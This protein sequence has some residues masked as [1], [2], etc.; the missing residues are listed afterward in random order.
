[1]WVRNGLQIKGQAMTYIQA[2]FCNSMV[3]MDIYWLQ[4]CAAHLPPDLFIDMCIDT[5]GV[6]EWLSMTPMSALQAAEQDAMVEGLLTFLAILVS[7]RTNLG[8]DEVSQSRLEVATLLACGDKTHSQLLELIPEREPEW[9]GA[10]GVESEAGTTDA[11]GNSNKPCIMSTSTALAIPPSMQMF[12]S[13]GVPIDDGERG[14]EGNDGG[15]GEMRALEEGTAADAA[16]DSTALV[17]PGA[18][19]LAEDMSLALAAPRDRLHRLDH[20]DMDASPTIDY[21]INPVEWGARAL[22]APPAESAPAHCSDE[23]QLHSALSGRLDSFALEEP[24]PDSD[25]HIGD[26]PHFIGRVLHKLAALD[27]RCADAIQMVRHSLWPHQRERE[28]EQRARERREKEERSRR[29]RERQ[30]AVMREFARRQQQFLS[31][32]RQLEGEQGERM[33]CEGES[34]GEGEWETW[35]ARDYDCV[36]C[37]TRARASAHDPIGLVV[38]LQSSSVLGHRRRADGGAGAL[39]L[40]EPERSRLAAHRAATAAAHH[41]R[42]HDDLHQHFDQE[43]WVLSVNVGW[44]GGVVAQSCGHHVHLRCLRAYLRSLA[45]P[46]PPNLLVERGEFLCP[47]CRQLANSVLPL[48]P[49]P[50]PAPAPAAPRDHLR[51]AADVSEM[52]E[53]E[54]V[55]MAVTELS[56]AMG[57]AMTDM[58]NAASGKVKLQHGSSPAAIF[59]FMASL[60]RTNL[61]C[62]LVQ[63][64]NTL[65]VRAPPRYKPRDDCIVPL[66]S[67]ASVHARALLVAGSALGVAHTW[68][69]LVP[70]LE[71]AGEGAAGAGSVAAVPAGGSRPVPL[72]LR[73]PTALL[74]QV[75]ELILPYLRISSLIRKHVYGGELPHVASARDEFRALLLYLQLWHINNTGMKLT[76]ITG[77]QCTTRYGNPN[78]GRVKCSKTKNL[79]GEPLNPISFVVIPL[80]FRKPDS[81]LSLVIRWITHVD[82]W[83]SNGPLRFGATDWRLAIISHFPRF[84]QA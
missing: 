71:D 41:Y 10:E 17:V 19:P 22:P 67:V 23:N 82:R 80:V 84:Y 70:A 63:R 14:E 3:D 40:S 2:N 43:S 37:N 35:R 7:S 21:D 29:A 46:R 57:L 49:P 76:V 6:R 47:L 75:Q 66:M 24:A 32:V 38:L 64:G 53:R 36:I 26:G 83:L 51:L 73:D 58:T 39:A 18:M 9:E 54:P 13:G 11:G 25:T 78:Y 12:R 60:V 27:P 62:E 30:A 45:A 5:F 28:A 77:S 31:A 34:E 1:M 68:R 55:R 72:L 52:L 16:V 33:E 61:E 8:N 20:L 69:A 56:E 74:L 48:A 4:I 59:T 81:I 42:L 50:P 15:E 65:V 79:V 44:E